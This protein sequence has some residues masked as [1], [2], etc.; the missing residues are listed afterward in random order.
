MSKKS[1]S[2]TS[3]RRAFTLVESLITM[4]IIGIVY[5]A[6]SSVIRPND[7]KREVLQKAGANMAYQLDFASKQILARNTV[8]YNF[9]HLKTSDGTEFLITDDGADEKLMKL[10]R[11]NLKGLKN[12]SVSSS[13]LGQTLINEQNALVADTT[14]SSFKYGFTLSNNA[15]LAIRL[16]G[17]CTTTETYIYNPTQPNKRTQANS[18]GVFFF[19]VNGDKAPNVLGLDQYVVAIGKNG[20]K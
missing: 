13:F 9:A 18:C 16:N 19:D 1:L 6:I 3:K 5:V 11:K 17:N 15:Y 14:P 10:F 7:I 20:L 2:K 12:V 8:N 4:I